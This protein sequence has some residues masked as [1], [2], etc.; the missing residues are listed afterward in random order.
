[1]RWELARG[2]HSIDRATASLTL[3][4][5]IDANTFDDL[6]AV[7]RRAVAA[8]HLT[9]RVDLPDAV[10]VSSPISIPMITTGVFGLSAPFLKRAG[11]QT[12]HLQLGETSSRG[13][14]SAV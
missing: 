11:K 12:L 1:M 7:A 3:P 8:R 6:V 14:V 9:N 4:N 2:D 10:E 5:F 13:A